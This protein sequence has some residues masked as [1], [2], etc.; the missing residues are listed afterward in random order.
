MISPV[1]IILDESLN[2]ASEIIRGVVVVQQQDILHRPVIAFDL[3]LCHRMVRTT[4]RMSESSVIEILSQLRRD[5]AGVR[6]QSLLERK[7]LLV[8]GYFG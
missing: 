2:L 8:K 7:G 5:V 6:V 3:S 1:V 4:S